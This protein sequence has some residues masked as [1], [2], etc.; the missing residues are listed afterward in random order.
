MTMMQVDLMSEPADLTAEQYVLG[1]MLMG[2]DRA[3]YEATMILSGPD[4]YDTKHQDLFTLIQDM[5]MRGEP[6]EVTTVNTAAAD[7]KLFRTHSEASLFVFNLLQSAS[8]PTNVGWYAQRVLGKAKLRNISRVTLRSYH[9]AMN[10]SAEPDSTVA[11]IVE[12]VTRASISHLDTEL[13]TASAAMGEAIDYL[14]AVIDGSLNETRVLTGYP[15]IDRITGGIQPGQLVLIA[16]RPGLGKSVTALDIARHVAFEQGKPVLFHT[17]E[18]SRREIGYRLLASLANINLSKFANPETLTDDDFAH[19]REAQITIDGAPFYLDDSPER[20]T[21][22][23]RARA[24]HLARQPE[25][26]ALV[27]VDYIGL[28]K[29]AN[30]SRI[31]SQ[32]VKIQQFSRDLKLIAKS[33]APVLAMA[34]L[35]RGLESRANRTPVLSD[36]RDSGALE[37]DSDIVILLHQEADGE[38]PRDTRA[39]EI[40]LIVAKNRNGEKGSVT[41]AQQYHYARFVPME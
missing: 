27:V 21:A 39:G 32:Q 3:V 9:A 14:Q 22:D 7:A 16:G 37:Q 24:A 31:E 30:E 5:W 6:V 17:L 15:G 10:P 33:V 36:L 41:L 12:N 38:D 4:F 19:M 28:L 26:L 8:T 18:M 35:N 20:T 34:Q 23:I 1:A 25:G 2:N 11:E 29:H 40:T 13:S